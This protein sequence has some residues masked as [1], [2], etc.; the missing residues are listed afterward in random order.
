MKNFNL[1]M[2]WGVLLILAGILFLAQN[3]EIIPSAWGIIWGIFFGL[4]GA[5]FLYAYT[6]DHSQWWAL[7][8][9]MALV[10]LMLLVFGDSLFPKMTN[11]L[12]GSIFL[13]AIAFSFWAIYLV[14][15][16]M[17]WAVIPAGALTTLALVAG[18]D[19]FVRDSGWIFLVGLGLTFAIVGIL[20][21]P[22]GR[23]T[24][25][26]IPAGILLVLGLFTSAALMNYLDYAWPIALILL[27]GYFIFRTFR[28]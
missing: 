18:I 14:N 20:P 19:P 6:T 11:Y 7:I 25:A 24:W 22:T 3:F 17:W 9:G 27:G 2:L 23:M 28:A 4:A 8:P 26:F 5:A 1:R 12:G 21:A 13:G 16:E 15:R 10:G